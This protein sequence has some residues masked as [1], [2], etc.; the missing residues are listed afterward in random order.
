LQIVTVDY[1]LPSAPSASKQRLLL[2][3]FEPNDDGVNASQIVVESVATDLPQSC[4]SYGDRMRCA[5][6]PGD[7]N[8]LASTLCGLIDEHEADVCLL[9]GQAP[10]RTRVTFERLATNLRDFMVPDRAGNLEAGTVILPTAPAAYFSTLDALGLAQGLITAGIPAAPSNHAGNHL[11]NQSL[12]VA[13]HY[14]ATARPEMRV[15]F[16]AHSDFASPGRIAVVGRTDDV[17]DHA[18]RGGRRD[19]SGCP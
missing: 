6:L 9:V 7:T 16:N 5:I 8:R 19:D 15:I 14:A 11:C 1:D 13:L 17:A 2:T 18:A 10:G 12:Y 4:T 3:G